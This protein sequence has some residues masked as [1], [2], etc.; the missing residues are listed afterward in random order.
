MDDKKGKG[1]LSRRGFIAG[2]TA[3]GAGMALAGCSGGADAEPNA[4]GSDSAMD[5]AAAAAGAASCCTGCSALCAFRAC[6]GT[7]EN[8][9]AGIGRFLGSAAHPES[10]GSLCAYGYASAEMLVSEASA[11]GAEGEAGRGGAPLRRRDDGSFE[12]TTW[13]DALARIGEALAAAKGQGRSVA[14]LVDECD[15]NGRYLYGLADAL[16]SQRVYSYA[17]DGGSDARCGE[18]QAI[19]ASRT[20]PDVEQARLVV[21]VGASSGRM[22]PGHA[23]RLTAARERG[24]VVVLV[25]AMVPFGM[26]AVDA[27]VPV[28][29]GTEAALLLA[30]AAALVR[31]GLEAE[32]ASACVEGLDAWRESLASCTPAWAARKTGASEADVEAFLARLCAAAPACAIDASCPGSLRFGNAAETAR[33]V[34]ALNALLGAYNVAGGTFVVPETSWDAAARHYATGSAE[35]EDRAADGGF[36]P[37]ADGGAPLAR[38]EAG[39]LFDL[40]EGIEAGEI[41]ALVTGAPEV[42]AWA[43]DAERAQ[44]MLPSLDVSVSICAGQG[45]YARLCDFVLPRCSSFEEPGLP[46]VAYAQ[47]PAVCRSAALIAP[48]DDVRPLRDVCCGIA[49]AAGVESSFAQEIDARAEAFLADAGLSSEALGDSGSVQVASLGVSYGDAPLFAT[50]S[51]KV[52]LRSAACADAGALEVCGFA[53]AANAAPENGVFR[54]LV[55]ALPITSAARASS[56]AVR[57]F[58]GKERLDRML[59]NAESARALGIAEDDEVVVSSSSGS[60]T[61][62]ARLVGHI[63]PGAVFLPLAAV[64]QDDGLSPLLLVEPHATAGFGTPDLSQATVTVRKVGA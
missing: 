38:V 39:S 17:S 49:E 10:V 44:R 58:V 50:G 12:E 20:V 30:G 42:L 19:G 46:H 55:A 14:V 23:A 48:A 28:L 8:G 24:A 57:A 53:D 40:V 33:V 56:E 43:C 18:L 62:R 61:W 1:A 13:D 52:E 32:G 31:E 41:G 51:G 59:I 26:P 45:Q 9:D 64:E 4:S 15:L 16:G 7:A 27:W 47:K 29:P 35:D 22:T 5:A 3:I 36:V 60:Q 34:C 25:D 21:V 6:L 54:L 37:R 11:S 2:A 63:H